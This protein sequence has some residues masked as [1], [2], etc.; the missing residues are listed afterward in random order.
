MVANIA[1]LLNQQYMT[2]ERKKRS[3]LETVIQQ[4]IAIIFLDYM[5]CF[6]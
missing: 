5:Q 4:V 6:L 2:S 1:T 3:I